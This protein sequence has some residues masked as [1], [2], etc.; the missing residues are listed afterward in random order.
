MDKATFHDRITA[1]L[2]NKTDEDKK[3]VEDFKSRCTYV[4]GGYDSPEAFKTLLDAIEGEEAAQSE[5]S[6]PA[7]RVFY[8]ALPPV[9]FYP[10]AK[11]VKQVLYDDKVTQRLIV[12]KPFGKDLES[13]N[14]LA[15]QLGS[16]FKEEEIF[17]IDHYLGKEMVKA[18]MVMKFANTFF[19]GIWNRQFINN[20]QITFKEPF[21]TDGRGG[22]FDQYGI[23]RDV[24]QNHLLQVLAMVAMERP[25]SL[26]A[27]DVRDEKVKVLKCIS[28]LSLDHLLLGQYVGDDKH[29]GYLDDKTVPKGSNCPT[30]A[31][32]VAFIDNERWAG[33]PFIL[34]AG[35]ALNE[36]KAEV[37]IQFNDVPG[38]IYPG[39]GRNE[40]VIRVQ[41]D[42]AVYLKMVNKKPGLTEETVMSELD[43]SYTSRYSDTYIPDAYEALI[44]DVLNGNSSNF[45]RSDELEAAW[46]IFTP[47]LHLI[48]GDNGVV[49][50]KYS[51]GS[52]GPASL[53]AF[54]ARYGYKRDDNYE[55][56]K[57][58]DPKGKL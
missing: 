32:A 39:V 21:G 10:V 53:D 58:T 46:K 57:A 28:P 29:P 27:E 43:L 6:S 35:K 33:V 5:C 1:Y 4:N 48:E 36:K 7:L 45:V 25:V 30:F 3:L 26:S 42:E 50:E 47:V 38:C 56:K 54:V 34:K 17:R 13:S 12:E 52:R 9:M 44:L 14:E 55:W 40:L 23:I 51:Y 8:F 15:E 37:R 20:V 31:T 22:Y 2:P 49:P 18:V 24:L 11:N 16:L 41:P 19:N